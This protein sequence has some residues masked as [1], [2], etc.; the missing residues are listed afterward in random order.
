MP[1]INLGSYPYYGGTEVRDRSIYIGNNRFIRVSS[2]RNNDAVIATIYESSNVYDENATITQLKSK[3]VVDAI[4]LDAYEICQ[5]ENGNIFVCGTYYN[6]SDDYILIFN[7]DEIN[8]DFNIVYSDNFTSSSTMFNDRSNNWC[9]ITPYGNK[10]VLYGARIGANGAAIIIDTNDMSV[11]TLFQYSNTNSFRYDVYSDAASHTV[12]LVDNFYYITFSLGLTPTYAYIVNLE[13]NESIF[14]NDGIISVCKLSEGKYLSVIREDAGRVKF[15]L[16][17]NMSPPISFTERYDFT[18]IVGT[19]ANNSDRRISIQPYTLDSD[20]FIVFYREY[21]NLPSLKMKV[22]NVLDPQYAIVSDNSASVPIEVT[23]NLSERTLQY[24]A[25][26]LVKR[27]SPTQFYSQV[28]NNVYEFY[29][30][31]V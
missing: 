27:L 12:S 3:V 29:Q 23:N 30:I 2:Q 15:Q 14:S 4:C 10:V 8:N 19:Y 18:P 17:E 7:Y 1:E 11:S 13:T 16:H 31:V 20:H 5:L 28:D 25:G 21:N 9:T 24:N 6:T 26:Q 22:V